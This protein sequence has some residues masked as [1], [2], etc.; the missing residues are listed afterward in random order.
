VKKNQRKQSEAMREGG[1]MKKVLIGIMLS[2]FCLLL[3]VEGVDAI[4]NFKERDKVGMYGSDDYCMKYDI[5][6]I[7]DQS[8]RLSA[9]KT[10]PQF[11]IVIGQDE[12]KRG[13]DIEVTISAQS[14]SATYYKWVAHEEAAD[15]IL[16]SEIPSGMVCPRSS[17]SYSYCYPAGCEEQPKE[18][19]YRKIWPERTRIW[20]DADPETRQWLSWQEN[21]TGD[22]LRY[23]FPD[24]W[25]LG[26]WTPDGPRKSG[27][28]GEGSEWWTFLYGD[29]LLISVPT[30]NLE[31]VY[32]PTSDAYSGKQVLGLWGSF[33]NFPGESVFSNDMEQCLLGKVNSEGQP[34]G[35]ECIITPGDAR[36]TDKLTSNV[37]MLT[38]KLNNVPM[39]LPGHWMI[40][41]T[42]YQY[43]AWYANGT[44]SEKDWRKI[45]G[46]EPI[47]E[48]SP[49][50]K[51]GP[52]ELGFSNYYI[53]KSADYSFDVYIII[54]TPCLASDPESCVN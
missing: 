16:S 41:V 38:I 31:K 5:L 6:S 23:V 53:M 4:S 42:G 32:E 3:R 1:T 30:T 14:G 33:S 18:T 19:I 7:V 40:G 12:F 20:L 39:D 13:L 15:W 22:P 50:L 8:L 49:N 52:Y 44:R 25:G 34:L 29:P 21:L 47:D 48:Y 27:F 17:G 24:D 37:T 35:G 46:L 45:K 51:I 43:P 26:A 10:E 54:S 36:S 28:E 9:K 2:G 11:P